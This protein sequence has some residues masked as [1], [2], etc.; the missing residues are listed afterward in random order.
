MAEFPSTFPKIILL[1]GSGELGKELTISLQRLGCH[2]IA[3]DSYA[4][5]PAMQVATESRVLDMTDSAGLERL[6]AETAPD[7]VVPEVE[8]LAVAALV[9]AADRGTRVIPSARVVELTFD[10]QG[11]R[12]LAAEHAKVPTS[13]YAFADSLESLRAAASEV[14]FPCFVKPTMSSSGHGQSR[15]ADA[16]ELEAAWNEAQAGA[17]AETGRVIVEEQ[18][19]FDFEITLLTVRHLDTTGTV[20]TSFCAPIGHRQVSGD[21]V[22]SWQPQQMTPE[23]LAKAQ[24]TSKAV[25]DALAQETMRAAGGCSSGMES[26]AGSANADATNPMLGIF[27]VEMFIKGD[28]VYFSELSPR[29]HD[30][31]MVTMI[32]QPQSEFD[33]HARAILGLPLDTSMYPHVPAGASTP[34][35]SPVE[36][37]DPRYSNVDAALSV[38]PDVQVRIFGKPV[39]HVGRRMAVA[40]ATGADTNSARARGK[41]AIEKLQIS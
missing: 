36:S 2:V 30:T 27:G 35:K 11:I 29:P 15:V 19:D 24:A 20:E 14:G 32:T 9:A 23:L 6:I 1:L 3:C 40:L 5:A 33:L 12:T 31:G 16:S 39:A 10:R 21:Y 8:K 34:L 28:E 13:R 41:A 37:E 4:G 26:S 17:R 7:L 22:E 18:I 25:L 38:G